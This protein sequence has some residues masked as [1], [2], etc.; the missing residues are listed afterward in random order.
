MFRNG[1]GKASPSWLSEHLSG[2]RGSGGSGLVWRWGRVRARGPCGS[3][4]CRPLSARP[5]ARGGPC[6]PLARK[7]HFCG[8]PSPRGGAPG[9]R[10]EC[11]RRGRWPRERPASAPR[12][13]D[14][15]PEPR[16]RV[17]ASSAARLRRLLPSVTALPGRRASAGLPRGPHAGGTR[18][19]PGG[20]SGGARSRED[21]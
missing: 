20:G 2:L 7:P 11:P 19:P 5:G 14:A 9:S 17:H 10:G 15:R 18:G 16:R 1:L 6:L 13:P 8:K 21:G 12:R 4:T 3:G